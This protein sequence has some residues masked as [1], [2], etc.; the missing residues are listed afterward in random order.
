MG[1]RCALFTE[2]DLKRALK[3]VRDAGLAETTR[4]VITRQGDIAIEPLTDDAMI[5]IN[6]IAQET[7]QD[8][9]AKLEVVPPDQ[10]SL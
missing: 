6:A 2:T 3:V 4:I 10:I 7:G 1:R 5:T 8:N 9:T